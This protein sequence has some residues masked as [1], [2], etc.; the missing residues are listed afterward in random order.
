MPSLHLAWAVWC[1]LAIWRLSPRGWARALAVLYPCSV[2][3]AVLSTGN[4]YL[5]DLL[6]GVATCAVAVGLVRLAPAR[7][8][9]R[10]W[11]TSVSHVTKLLLSRRSC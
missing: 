8:R 11:A 7:H 2:A 6:A 9:P 5:L 1:A 10:A 3:L 4:H